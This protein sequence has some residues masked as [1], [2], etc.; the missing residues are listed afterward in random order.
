[1]SAGCHQ[2]PAQ[3]TAT[4]PRHS[5]R[6]GLSARGP[7][8]LPS[9]PPPRAPGA[10][11]PHRCCTAAVAPLPLAA[12]GGLALACLGWRAG[13][14]KAR[15]T[16]WDCTCDRWRE[17]RVRALCVDR[18]QENQHPGGARVVQVKD[19]GRPLRAQRLLTK[20]TGWRYR[21]GTRQGHV[22]RLQ[23]QLPFGRVWSC[24]CLMSHHFQKFECRNVAA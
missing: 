23:L 18:I 1:M 4:S 20:I 13:S 5:V 21:E 12:R 9:L 15:E 7:V 8:L 24:I 3:L 14:R 10:H 17:R 22:G 16:H 19:R 11:G 6:V 2:E